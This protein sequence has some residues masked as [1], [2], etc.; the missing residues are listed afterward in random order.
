VIERACTGT[1]EDRLLDFPIPDAPWRNGPPG[2]RRWCEPWLAM[3]GR[4]TLERAAGSGSAA[5]G[6]L[7]SAG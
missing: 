6:A 3:M 2:F 5:A 7:A 1:L 4:T